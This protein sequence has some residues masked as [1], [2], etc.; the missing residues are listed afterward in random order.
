[1]CE[2]NSKEKNF[3]D[4]VQRYSVNC[5]QMP[6]WYSTNIFKK[7]Y[8][9]ISLRHTCRNAWSIE[10]KVVVHRD[11]FVALY[12]GLENFRPKLGFS[13]SESWY[14]T[15][16]ELYISCSLYNNKL[17][18]SMWALTNCAPIHAGKTLHDYSLGLGINSM[19][20]REQKHQKIVKYSDKTTFHITV[21][22]VF[23]DMSILT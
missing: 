6:Q 21:G 4:V 17:S 5:S 12:A 14:K 10:V 3:R 19:E 9:R 7:I 16:M 23:S 18:P 22:L 8:K 20:G 2:F 11:I 15:K 13:I 1:M